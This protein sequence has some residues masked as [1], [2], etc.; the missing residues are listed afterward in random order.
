VVPSYLDTVYPFTEEQDRTY[1]AATLRQAYV[2]ARQADLPVALSRESDGVAE[3]AKLYLV[4]ST[5]HLLATTWQQLDR[6]AAGGATV[7]VSYSRGAHAVHRGPWHS[8]FNEMFGVEHQLGYPPAEAI[9]DSEVT[10]TLITD[11]GKLSQGAKL[12]FR[13]GGSPDSMGFVPVTPAGAEVIA[14]DSHGRPAL[15]L[16]RAGRGS[17]ILCTYPVEHMASSAAQPEPSGVGALYDALAIHAGIRRLVTVPEPRVG[18]DIVVRDD[19]QHFAW[20]VSQAEVP[21]TVRP[22]FA[23]GLRLRALDGSEVSD[24]VTLEPFGV[25]VF[26]LDGVTSPAAGA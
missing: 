23:N 21:V 9:T 10:F 20:L 8:G 22:Q 17:V 1:L 3:D 2:C 15:L 18:A 24:T 5:K 6:L 7:Y 19:G 11:F 16:R 12:T 25:G 4:P 26:A 13:P 14:V